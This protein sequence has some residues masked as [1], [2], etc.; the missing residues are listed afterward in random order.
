ML[1]DEV[2]EDER[3]FTPMLAYFE[4]AARLPEKT[5]SFEDFLPQIPLDSLGIITYNETNT[6]IIQYQCN[7]CLLTFKHR[8]PFIKHI[9]YIHPLVKREPKYTKVISDSR[10]LETRITSK[11]SKIK[12]TRPPA[13]TC[14]NCF[15]N[16]STL[17]AFKKHL[18]FK[19]RI[20]DNDVIPYKA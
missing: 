14:N 4:G 15:E 6:C 7:T 13:F 9:T 20:T 5:L 3:I 11:Q 10:P 2:T 16:A 8:A 18:L 1:S 19:H 17:T 12:K